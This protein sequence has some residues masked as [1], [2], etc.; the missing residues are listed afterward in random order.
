MG[1][2]N[3]ADSEA[4]PDDDLEVEDDEDLLAVLRLIAERAGKVILGYYGPGKSADVRRKED[5]TPVTEADEAAETLI[6]GALNTL[7]PHI[8]VVSEEAAAAGEIPDVSEGLFWLVDPLDGTREFLS[9]NGEFT[10]NIALIQ[11]GE[12]IAGVV[13]APALGMTWAGAG[14]G[15]ATVSEAD[16]P[17]VPIEVRAM[18]EEG[19]VVVASRR[20]GDPTE[21]DAFLADYRVAE[22]VSAGS[23]LKFCLVA[24]GKADLYPRFGR[25]MEWD[26]AA[27]HAVLLA[28]GGSVVEAE[29]GEP[30]EYGKPGFENPFFIA[31]G[32]D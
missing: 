6:L 5:E 32:K 17:A 25:T 10:V 30:L 9:Q 27:G 13:H 11:H 20:H 19:A 16:Q 22:Q 7:T 3:G 21:L 31:R 23:S 14:R 1:R 24:S 18:P 15:S 29:S 8:P 4:D 26:T 12:P 28:A 2:S